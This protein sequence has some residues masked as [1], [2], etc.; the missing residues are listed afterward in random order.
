MSKLYFRFGAMNCGKTTALLQVAHNYSEND[1]NVIVIKPSIDT[2]GGSN[3]DSRLG[4]QREVDILIKPDESF[5]DY[6][7]NWNNKVDC[8]LVD[9]AQFLSP[10]QVEELWTCTKLFEIPVICYG[11]KTNFK[12]E[13]FDGSKRLIELADSIEEMSTICECGKK[14]RYNARFVNG[15]FAKVG[16]SVVIDGANDNVEYKPLCGKCYL[17]NRKYN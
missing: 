10:K 13:L 9:E 17:Y 6:Y 15:H 8:I 5:E 1:K 14:A 12:S 2:K 7:E 11:L 3:L 4:C 16:D